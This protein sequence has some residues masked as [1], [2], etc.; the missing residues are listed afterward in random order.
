MGGALP[1]QLG[2]VVRGRVVQAEMPFIAEEEHRGR[3]EAL[4][5]R[6]DAEHGLGGRERVLPHGRRSDAAGVEQVAADDHAIR[7][8]GDRL[9]GDEPVDE[10]IH[11]RQ[12]V[13]DRHAA[14]YSRA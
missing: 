7:D 4:G 9:L 3:G 6:G 12:R 13:V 1:L 11:L 5:H 14:D 8:A 10:P 2:D